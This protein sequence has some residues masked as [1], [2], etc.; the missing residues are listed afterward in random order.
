MADTFRRFPQMEILICAKD[1]PDNGNHLRKKEG[2]IIDVREVGM[3]D[4]LGSQEVGKYI[5]IRCEGVEE[6]FYEDLTQ[7]EGISDK[8]RYHI[9]LEELDRQI[10]I[11]LIKARDPNEKYQPY[12]PIDVNDGTFINEMQVPLFNPV[13]LIEDK[14]TLILKSE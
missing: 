13:G 10:S 5:V 4:G 6:K 11:D 12:V 1:E 7:S 8:R 14:Q 2:D 9:P 3:V